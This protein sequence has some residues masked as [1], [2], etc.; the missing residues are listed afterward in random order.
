MVIVQAQ[1][2]LSVAK[3]LHFELLLEGAIHVSR[4]R[5]D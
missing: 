4:L 3:D 2:G 5:L 1:T